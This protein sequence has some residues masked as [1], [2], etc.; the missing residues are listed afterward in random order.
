MRI[1]FVLLLM[2]GI[3]NAQ[4]IGDG[5]GSSYGGTKVASGG[6]YSGPGDIVSGSVAWWGLRGYNAAYSTGSNNSVNIRR[7][8]DNTTTN[9][10]ILSTG[11]VDSA[12]GATFCAST[13]CYVTEWYD[14]TGNGHHAIQAT[15]A[16]QPQI[17]FSGCDGTAN[18]CIVGYPTSGTKYLSFSLPTLAQP[19]SMSTVYSNPSSNMYLYENQMSGNAGYVGGI[20]SSLFIGGNNLQVYSPFGFYSAS[21][22]Y[23]GSSSYLYLNGIS[24]TG[25][26]PT[27]NISASTD[28]FELLVNYPSGSGATGNVYEVGFWNTAFTGT[29][30]TNLCHQQYLYWGTGTSC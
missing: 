21:G 13:T 9:L 19:V 7:A 18:A 27:T 5:K 14:Q 2:I 22:I 23:N 28:V 10:L 25:T 1:I 11:A 20:Y 15:A 8:S 6:S 3:A 16:N 30:A 29:N 24:N 26:L 12:T 17:L 4:I